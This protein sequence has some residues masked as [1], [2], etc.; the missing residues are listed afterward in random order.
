MFGQSSMTSYLNKKLCLLGP[1][2]CIAL[3]ASSAVSGSLPDPPAAAPPHTREPTPVKP[4]HEAVDQGFRMSVVVG[5]TAQVIPAGYAYS[6]RVT[7]PSGQQ[8][9][10]VGTQTA[11]GG[12]LLGGLQVTPPRAFRRFTLGITMGLGG[13][14]SWSKAPIPEGVSTPFS[15]NNLLAAIQSRYAYHSGWSPSFSP[16]I[17]HELGSFL[18]NRCRI[19]YQYWSQSG[20]YNG[21]FVPT[22]GSPGVAAYNVRL[23]YSAHLVR[24][25][26]NNLTELDDSQSNGR[27][28]QRYGLIQQAGL[29]VGT[30]RTLTIFLGVGPFWG[31]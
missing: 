19:G 7:L 12:A 26:I 6:T 2:L 11:R 8:L 13:L 30:N 21:A 17:E 31:F 24:F 14:A 18:G 1:A 3:R 4:P 22:D 5:I 27:P 25:S 15:R 10:Y 28:R 23:K 20:E 16:Y 29:L 9:N